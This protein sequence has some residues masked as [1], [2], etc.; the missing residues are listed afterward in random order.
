MTIREACSIF[1]D[2]EVRIRKLGP[3]TIK[4]YAAALRS[5]SRWADENGLLVLEDL[6]ESAARAWVGSWTWRPST[7]GRRLSQ[8]KAFF[9]FT[10]DFHVDKN[11]NL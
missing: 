6:D 10:T 4:G 2:Q 5:L 9:R 11:P 7:T 8:L 3:E 1:L